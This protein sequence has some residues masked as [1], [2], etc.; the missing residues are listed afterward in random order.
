[1][2]SSVVALVVVVMVLVLDNLVAVDQVNIE[3]EM[4]LLFPLQLVQR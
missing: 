2:L 3:V 4:I 1:M